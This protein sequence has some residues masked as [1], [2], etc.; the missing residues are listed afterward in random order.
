MVQLQAEL[1]R[2]KRENERLWVEREILKK[3]QHSSRKN[4]CEIFFHR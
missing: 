1:K 4:R 3:G 2:L